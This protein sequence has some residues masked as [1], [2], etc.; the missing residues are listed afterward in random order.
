MTNEQI[1]QLI[2]ALQ[3]QLKAE[4]SSDNTQ[5]EGQ[6]SNNNNQ[7]ESQESK[8]EEVETNGNPLNDNEE[9][10]QGID[11]NFEENIN[12]QEPKGADEILT[13]SIDL[14]FGTY[15]SKLQ[16]CREEI[17]KLKVALNMIMTR[18]DLVEDVTDK[19]IEVDSDSLLTESIKLLV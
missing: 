2:L 4:E 6:E 8:G 13:Q 10:K 18:I 16:Q 9:I 5:E 17:D 15:E 19:F 7:E 12:I 1:N 3:S 11:A 14:R